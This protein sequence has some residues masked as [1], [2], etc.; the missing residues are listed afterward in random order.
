VRRLPQRRPPEK[1]A[2]QGSDGVQVKLQ[3]WTAAGGP[4]RVDDDANPATPTVQL[5]AVSVDP[6]T[7]AVTVRFKRPPERRPPLRLH[8]AR[9]GHPGHNEDAF[10]TYQADSVTGCPTTTA[11]AAPNDTGPAGCRLKIPCGTA[12]SASCP[13]PAINWTVQHTGNGNYVGTI[14]GF[15]AAP[16]DGTVFMLNEHE[17]GRRDRDRGRHPRHPD[18]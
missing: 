14:T 12:V 4:V 3:H 1:H 9:P 15:T 18:P 16:A 11:Q 8:P 5:P 17:P 10:W 13:N 6:T 7:F 2:L